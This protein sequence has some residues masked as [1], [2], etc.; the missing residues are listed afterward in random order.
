MAD[1]NFISWNGSKCKSTIQVWY[2]YSFFLWIKY[3]VWV[4]NSFLNIK[5][6][7]GSIWTCYL[8][9]PERQRWQHWRPRQWPEE[10]GTCPPAT[11]LTEISPPL[12]GPEMLEV[13]FW[14]L[15]VFDLQLQTT[16]HR[17]AVKFEQLHLMLADVLTGT[18]H[19]YFVDIEPSPRQMAHKL[20]EHNSKE[21]R[22]HGPGVVSTKPSCQTGFDDLMTYSSGVTKYCFRRLL[23][24]TLRIIRM[25]KGKTPVNRYYLILKYQRLYS[26]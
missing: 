9:L 11:E 13:L 10:G 3:A 24:N 4:A 17:P 23:M 16:K 5:S 1:L 26:R 14:H 6:A 7:A 12:S 8:I 2:G 21:E 25:V 15:I 20:H 19:V 18:H 22:P